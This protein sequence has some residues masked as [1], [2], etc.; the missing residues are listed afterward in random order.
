M[1]VSP[2]GCDLGPAALWDTALK[3]CPSPEAELA[4][5]CYVIEQIAGLAPLESPFNSELYAIPGKC[6]LNQFSAGSSVQRYDDGRHDI[7][8]WVRMGPDLLILTI[9]FIALVYVIYRIALAAETKLEPKVDLQLDDDSMRSSIQ[10][11]LQQQRR[12]DQL[13]MDIREKEKQGKHFWLGLPAENDESEIG[14]TIQVNPQ[15]KQT[16]KPLAALELQISNNIP[17][18]QVAID[19]DSS[20]LMVLNNQARRVIRHIPGM[21]M[22]L[23]QPQVHSIINPTQSML[24]TVTSEDMFGRHPETQV[25]QPMVPLLD[26]EKALS[27]K[28]PKLSYA[29]D[30]RIGIL[31]MGAPQ[32]EAIQLLVPFRFSVEKKKEEVAFP[33]FRLLLRMKKKK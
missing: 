15:G 5:E 32:F 10:Q 30:L 31:P 20:S 12:A 24:A 4:K 19:W 28:L 29:L 11:Q 25:L 3:P 33:L 8:A 16:I 14:L 18:A 1:S 26:F 6:V 17:S 22:G 9:Y 21:H 2:E 13:K 27:L 23:N 7:P